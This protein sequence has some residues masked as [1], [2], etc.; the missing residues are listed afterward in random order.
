[1][2]RA[3]ALHFA[4]QRVE[5]TKSE[6]PRPLTDAELARYARW[7][8]KRPLLSFALLVALP[9]IGEGVCRLLGAW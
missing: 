1:M 7:T 5:A 4:P 6:T 9:F 8:A 2:N 3:I